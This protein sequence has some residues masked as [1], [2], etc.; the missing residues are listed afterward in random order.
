MQTY[1]IGIYSLNETKHLDISIDVD[2]L[3]MN[4]FAIVTDLKAILTGNPLTPEGSII[5]AQVEDSHETNLSKLV[6]AYKDAGIPQI[7]ALPSLFLKTIGKGNFYAITLNKELNLVETIALVNQIDVLQNGGSYED[8][9]K[10]Y[11]ELYKD[12]LSH[13]ELH[14]NDGA[15]K[16]E[17]GPK[18]KDKRICRYCHKD[19]T[20]TTF[21]EVA[22]T[23][24][25]GFGNKGI[26]TNDE[27]D[28]CN[29]YFGREVEPAL[30]EYLDFFRVWIGVQ[31]KKG[32]IHHKY[33]G[34]Y[35]FERLANNS[36]KLDITLTDE[37]MAAL[38]P[39]APENVKLRSQQEVELQNIYRSL[40]KYALGV[41]QPEY[42]SPFD[43]TVEWLLRKREVEKL[44]LVR[45]EIALE[46]VDQ[47]KV[48]VMLRKSDDE[49]LP[50]AVSE[51]Q[52]MNIRFLLI[53]P[54]CDER[55]HAFLGNDYWE[56]FVSVF[57]MYKVIT[58]QLQD[59]SDKRKRQLVMNVGFEK[60]D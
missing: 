36:Y 18:D 7:N 22:H 28:V 1:T 44:P 29:S 15:K 12:L 14:G 3:D 8:M 33:G 27:C 26:I 42:M 45:M 53:I 16:I 58:W 11:G 43:K 55:D 52:M 6:A 51:I 59:F 13:Y 23:I 10:S 50:Y 41:L 9:M 49:S 47:P 31:G 25:E 38:K 46:S 48:I 19:S 20:E 17:I 21:K 40:V 32:Q 57:K 54:L 5:I 34:N 2:G 30:M 60:R 24:S 56:R 4:Q 35:E 37:E 39:G